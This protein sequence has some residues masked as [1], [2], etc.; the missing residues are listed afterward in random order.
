MGRACAKNGLGL[1]ILGALTALG[2][3]KEAPKAAVRVPASSKTARPQRPPL[4]L[5]RDDG[6][7][8]IGAA[9]D[10][11]H[12]TGDCSHIVHSIYEKAGFPYHYADSKDL[13]T[14]IPGFR[15]VVHPQPG[16][17]AVWPGHAAIV[18]NPAQHSFFGGTRSGLRVE[19]Y[20]LAYWKHR[21]PPRFF[22]Y[23]KSAPAGVSSTYKTSAP[24]LALAHQ[25]QK[26]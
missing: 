17:L 14:G 23:V 26:P 20:D 12:A 25:P 15:K 3:A 11:R 19:S 4:L 1:L 5:T 18:V 24:K 16:D 7:A 22:R 2:S 10:T 9:L 13:Y 21:G 6:Q 8:I